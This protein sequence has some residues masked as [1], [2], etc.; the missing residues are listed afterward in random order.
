MRGRVGGADM[1][2]TER[3]LGFLFAGYPDNDAL[4]CEIRCLKPGA[5]DGDH[6]RVV[7]RWFGLAP[8]Y[9]VKAADYCR[10]MAPT[11]DVYVGVLPRRG[12]G[13]FARD[14]THA[15]MLFCDIDAGDDPSGVFDLLSGSATIMHLSALVE[16]PSGGAHVYWGL[17]V[18]EDLANSEA[19]AAYRDA[20]KRVV[21]AIGGRKPGA[22]AD[23]RATDEARILRVPG[24]L[25]HK[26]SPPTPI[27]RW[28]L[29]HAERHDLR[30]WNRRLPV[31]SPEPEYHAFTPRGNHSL[32]H[33]GRDF[34]DD[35]QLLDAAMRE[36]GFSALW[37]GDRSRYDG[38]DSR[39]DMALMTRLAWWTAC[40]PSRM[41]RLF[42]RSVL[43]QR[44]KWQR[45][46]YRRR[47]INRALGRAT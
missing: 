47:T 19:R 13:G 45:E 28:F 25:Y 15:R 17:S 38:D 31:L 43:G 32:P 34:G 40:N 27:L 21:R 41:E 2:C 35:E 39:A 18:T 26:S 14:V 33:A 12:K 4:S 5:Q 42:S 24:T 30:W 22:H 23:A 7:R 37:L 6:E 3:F 16:T 1:T 20:L 8:E 36:P 10:A 11:H 9:L 46:D 29:S 44:K